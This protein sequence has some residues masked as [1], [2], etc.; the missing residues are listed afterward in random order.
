VTDIFNKNFFFS[1]A[2][3]VPPEVQTLIAPY[4]D[5]ICEECPWEKE[6][7]QKNVGMNF[8]VVQGSLKGGCGHKKKVKKGPIF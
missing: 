3:L 2:T 7:T 5:Q 6:K 1:G 4:M 8:N